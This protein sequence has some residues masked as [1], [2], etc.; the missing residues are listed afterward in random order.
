MTSKFM[1]RLNYLQYNLE[2]NEITETVEW[3]LLLELFD[4]SAEFPAIFKNLRFYKLLKFLNFRF[5]KMAGDSAEQL[6]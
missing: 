3:K 1:N 5:L 6:F 2:I 4:V